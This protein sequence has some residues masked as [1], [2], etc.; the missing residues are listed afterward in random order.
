MKYIASCSGGKDSV[1]TILLAL[2]HGE[3]LHEAVYCEVMFSKDISGEV[4]EH[5]DFV[6]NRLR[7]FV[8]AQGIKFVHL[9]SKKTF[10]DCFFH[11]RVRG[12]NK[13]KYVGF[14]FPM[15]CD[16]NR[17]CKMPPIRNYYKSIAEDVTQYVGI[18]KDETDRLLRLMGT[19]KV[20]LLE[21]HGVSR[22]ETWQL[23]EK[24]G[25]LSPAYLWSKRNGC[26]FCPNIKDREAAH[27]AI[28]HPK[29]WNK[30][31]ELEKTENIVR[32]RLTYDEKPSEIDKR[33]SQN[34]IGISF[35][36]LDYNE[37][38]NV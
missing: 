33:I 13:G 21:K 20:S 10:L 19:N 3:P 29:L 23:C 14:P 31:I 34:G 9:V 2:K 5:R 37:A 35:A 26:W 11:V 28:D 6:L 7:P 24:H 4:P 30:L 32:N 18:E 1:A 16:I 12:K 36:E 8:K 25:L 22:A 15:M 38:V 27:L 17:D